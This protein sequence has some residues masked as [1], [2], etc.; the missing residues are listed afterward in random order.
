MTL[1][2]TSESLMHFC[3]SFAFISIFK[4]T[5]LKTASAEI[6]KS[7]ILLL[8]LYEEVPGVTREDTL[9]PGRMLIVL[10][11][12]QAKLRQCARRL[13]VGTARFSSECCLLATGQK[14]THFIKTESSSSDNVIFRNFQTNGL[15]PL[16]L[17][18]K[19]SN[20]NPLLSDVYLLVGLGYCHSVCLYQTGHEEHP[21]S[22]TS[23]VWS[24]ISFSKW[25]SS[26]QLPQ[27]IL[28]LFLFYFIIFSHVTGMYIWALANIFLKENRILKRE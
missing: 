21:A 2:P 16:K 9:Q 3:S 4:C 22:L 5:A 6:C 18:G 12:S 20:K 7:D 15:Q 23:S 28:E 13:L 25:K 14:P 1:I 11:T 17:Y 10:Y 27:N 26:M 8:I 24:S 19:Y